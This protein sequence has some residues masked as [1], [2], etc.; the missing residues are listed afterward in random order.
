MGLWYSEKYKIRKQENQLWFLIHTKSYIISRPALFVDLVLQYHQEKERFNTSNS[1]NSSWE[2]QEVNNEYQNYILIIGESMRKDYLSLYGYPLSTTPFLEKSNGIFIDGYISSAGYTAVSLE[3]TL[4]RYDVKNNIT[5]YSDNIIT[6]AQKAGFKTYWL[7]NQ[8]MWGIHDNTASRIAKLTNEQIF[9]RSNGNLNNTD[10]TI[11][12]MLLLPELERLISQPSQKPRLFILHLMGSHNPY[13]ARVANRPISFDFINKDMSCFLES[14]KQ[15]DE[16]IKKAI[17][18]ASTQ[19]GYSLLYFSDHGLHHHNKENERVTLF[20][21]TTYRQNYEVPL[22]VISSHDTKR[23]TI[24]TKRSAFH[25][26]HGFAEWLQIK[27]PSLNQANSFFS[28][29][30]D[31][32]PIKVFNGQS[33]INFDTLTDDPVIYPNNTR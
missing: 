16:L 11:S 1:K 6:L 26:I 30:H 28:E 3:R 31:K 27:E 5:H 2:I 23:K 14:L 10:K 25:F 18:I 21:G 32:E 20:H 24:K 19:G 29:T 22:F 9:I 15:T 7:T 8:N 4:Y 13:C 33:I 12:D 17:D